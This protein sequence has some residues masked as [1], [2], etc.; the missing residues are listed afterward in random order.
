LLLQ[1]VGYAMTSVVGIWRAGL[2]PSRRARTTGQFAQFE[3]NDE[4]E[5]SG[6]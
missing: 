5:R 4:T 2:W 1:Q 6:H 3:A